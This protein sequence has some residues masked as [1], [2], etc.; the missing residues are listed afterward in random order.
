MSADKLPYPRATVLTPIALSRPH[1]PA[2]SRGPISR[3]VTP[4][5]ASKRPVAVTA[6]LSGSPSSRSSWVNRTL[7]KPGRQPQSRSSSA[8]EDEGSWDA[9]RGGAGGADEAADLERADIE[10]LHDLA[11]DPA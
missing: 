10:L 7:S 3:S 11:N 9:A 4:S 8:P 5:F 1:R 6:W 2:A